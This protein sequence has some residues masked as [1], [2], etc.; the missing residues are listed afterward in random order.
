M[1]NFNVM[2]MNIRTDDEELANLKAVF[3]HI[4]HFHKTHSHK[5]AKKAE[6]VYLILADKIISESK[7][8]SIQMNIDMPLMSVEEV[9]ETIKQYQKNL[10]R[11]QGIQ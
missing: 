11:A 6:E 8:S 7:P 10:E 1:E 3:N 5:A 2:P 4:E 9:T